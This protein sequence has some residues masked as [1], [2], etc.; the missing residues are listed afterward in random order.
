MG[1]DAYDTK[2]IEP[3]SAFAEEVSAMPGGE[4]LKDCFACGTCAAGCPVTA[5][6]PEYNPRK[7]I[8]EVTLGMREKVLAS[9]L[10]WYC[11][12]CYRC[13]AR[14]PQK[15]NFTDVMR[16]LRH[17]AVRGGYA[18]AAMYEGVAQVELESQTARKQMVEQAIK[19]MNTTAHRADS[20]GT[21]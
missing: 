13:S 11:V 9:P 12:S 7:I 6:H 16:V 1:T 21:G 10:I 15:V 8:R 14:C 18:S 4:R 19:T 2:R 17:L 5:V 3:D 20:R